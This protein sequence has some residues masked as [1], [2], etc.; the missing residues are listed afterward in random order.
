MEM[1]VNDFTTVPSRIV[2]MPVFA[3]AAELDFDGNHKTKRKR[4]A[5]MQTHADAEVARWA[6]TRGAS[7][8]SLEKLEPCGE[9]CEQLL[10]TFLEWGVRSSLEI[11]AQRRGRYDYG[12]ESVSDWTAPQDYGL[13]RK[14][15]GAD[16]AL[17]V[18]LRDTRETTG[19]LI[20]GAFIGRR[21]YFKQVTVACAATLDGY[22]QMK[23]CHADA[24]RWAN[25]S[26]EAT[27]RAAVR[28]LLSDL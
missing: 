25:L 22:A 21:T 3:G 27:V 5:A 4:A 10:E 28:E 24:D 23:W 26:D 14:A 16:V 18:V 20:G 13:L 9:R 7:M 17:L 15:L 19:R 2:V 12:R 6:S 11:A 1:R 8:L